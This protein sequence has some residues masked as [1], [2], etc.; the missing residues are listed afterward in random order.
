MKKCKPRMLITSTS[1]TFPLE[2]FVSGEVRVFRRVLRRVF[3]R[4]LPASVF[5]YFAGLPGLRAEVRVLLVTLYVI[6]SL[7]GILRKMNTLYIY[8]PLFLV[9]ALI[10]I[11]VEENCIEV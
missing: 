2:H 10:R 5:F 11:V 3:R 8:I 9:I 7:S 4:G 1:R 6:E